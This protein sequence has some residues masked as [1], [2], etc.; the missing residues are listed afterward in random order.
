MAEEGEPPATDEREA[1]QA[2]H[3]VDNDRDS[4]R[5]RDEP[6]HEAENDGTGGEDDSRCCRQLHVCAC[7]TRR[8]P[9]RCS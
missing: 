8:P 7:A 1:A 3:E 4:L 2:E 6:E 9:G 5:G